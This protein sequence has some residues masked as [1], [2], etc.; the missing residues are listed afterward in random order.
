MSGQPR[1]VLEVLKEMARTF[2]SMSRTL[3]E[4]AMAVANSDLHWTKRG[5]TLVSTTQQAIWEE[6]SGTA[7]YV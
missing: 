6:A 3:D 2:C 1:L 7:T 4:E 5:A